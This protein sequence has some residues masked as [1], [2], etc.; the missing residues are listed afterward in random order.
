MI[1]IDRISYAITNREITDQGYLKVP[2]R[3]ARTGIQK[4][5]ASELGLMDRRP[6]EI[7]SVFRPP[8]EVFAADSL[9]SYDNA[10]MTDDHPSDM[11]NAES[12]KDVAVGHAISTG[13]K[14][15]DFVIVDLLI[16]DKKAI[17]AVQSGKLELSAGYEA[18][19]IPEQG[20]TDSGEPY[21]FVQRKIRINHIALVDKARAG[22]EARLFDKLQEADMPIVTLDNG[23]VVE[24]A[25]KATSQLIQNT[26]DGL[27]KKVTDA[28]TEQAK[29]IKA[30]DEAEAKA[31][32]KEEELEEEKKKTSDAA[33]SERVKLITTTRDAAKKIAGD[34]FVC[35]SMD[36]NTIRREAMAKARPTVD[37]KSK[38]D[39]YVQAAWDMEYEKKEQEDEDEEEKKSKASD[40]QKNLG[41]D[42]KDSKAGKDAQKVLDE[43]YDKKQN[44]TA[45]A[46]KG[47]AK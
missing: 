27:R 4:Y 21:E 26:I 25:D 37:W 10:D 20:V 35:D 5:L 18:E 24:V 41:K 42:F 39:N 19:Y 9:A 34:D 1:V 38:S 11:V 46:W 16:K 32:K 23:N 15:G 12:F 8:E 43:A 33:I 6:N 31:E 47:G 44:E 13:R 30:K 45:V 36:V 2:G 40:S 14:D 28:E 3:V 17:D 22:R 29:A 7:V